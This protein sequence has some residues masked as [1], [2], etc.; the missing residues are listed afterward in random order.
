[1]QTREILKLGRQL[2][3]RMLLL[4]RQRV[5]FHSWETRHNRFLWRVY[6]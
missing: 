3:K 5:L 1:M 6:S 2:K 4:M